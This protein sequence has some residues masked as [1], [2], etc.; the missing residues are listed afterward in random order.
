MSNT[1]Q[2]SV[3]QWVQY[4]QGL[5]HRQIDLS[6]ERVRDV[7]KRLLPDGLASKVITLAGT[8]GKGSTAELLASIYRQAGYRVGKYTSPHLVSFNERTVINGEAVTDKSLLE[9]F[10]HIEQAR[11]D[12]PITF[13][14]YG[15]LLALDLFSKSK[16]DIA[17]MEVGLGGRLDA[18]NILNHD[19]SVI[20][21]IAK[22]HTAWLGNT[23]EEIA[24]EKA[25]V[26]R[27]DKPLIVGI[28]SPPATIVKHA[29]DV[30]ARLKLVDRD[31]SYRL[32]R[33]GKT[34]NWHNDDA[35]LQRLPLP[36]GQAGVQLNNGALALQAV[37]QLQVGLPVS[38]DQIRMGIEKAEVLGR[39]QVI[40]TRPLIVLDVSHNE[41]SVLRLTQFI[42]SI[43]H[44]GGRVLAVCGMLRDK[45]VEASLAQISPIV[46]AWYLASIDNERGASAVEIESKVAQTSERSIH[47]FDFVEQAYENALT[48]LTEHD[49]LL[50]FGSF[51]IVGD[52]LSHLDLA[53]VE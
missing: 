44:G 38:Y 37:S 23:I 46:N 17:I 21:S 36:Y 28:A 35:A 52:I 11:G 15:T 39:C 47:C 50:V 3:E 8:N 12:I 33:N 19:V 9:S 41:S 2:R 51:H 27:A 34:W 32:D 20:T 30:D 5:H 49:C 18:V 48:S 26:A 16:V 10:Q 31:F 43:Y 42:K 45:E 22:D 24:Y 6:L 1:H 14:E 40:Q 13:F 25:G 53:S 29:A 7:Y 4:I